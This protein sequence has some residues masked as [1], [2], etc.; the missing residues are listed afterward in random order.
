M[1]FEIS[2][3]GEKPTWHKS[4]Q[5]LWSSATSFRGITVLNDLYG[6]L[7]DFFVKR[8]GVRTM[9]A[10]MVY[11]KLRSKDSAMSVDDVKETIMAFNSFLADSHQKFD[12]K[13]VVKSCVFPVKLPNGL[14]E[15]QT[16]KKSFAL[17]NHTLLANDFEGQAKFLDFG[18]A[19]VRALEPFILWTGLQYRYLSKMVKEN[20]FAD[21]DSAR[22]VSSIDRDIKC[23]AHALAR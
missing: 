17:L 11:D 7:K 6:D 10:A 5:C 2:T 4:P 15:L 3:S 21:Y 22:P 13:P 9:T 19:E 14:V 23:K 12:P 20:T 1:I 16:G 8:L 18:L